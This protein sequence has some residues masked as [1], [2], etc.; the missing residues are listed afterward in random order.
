MQ[1][2]TMARINDLGKKDELQPLFEE[3]LSIRI[4]LQEM[5]WEMIRRNESLLRHKSRS[6]WLLDRDV[7]S[8][9]FH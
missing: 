8:K 7:N 6:N 2:E 5:F 1:Q 3:E 9:Y 4:Q